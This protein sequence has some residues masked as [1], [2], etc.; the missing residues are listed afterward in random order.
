MLPISTTS[1]GEYVFP[2]HRAGAQGS[3]INQTNWFLLNQSAPF[4]GPGLR[5]LGNNASRVQG[6]SWLEIWLVESLVG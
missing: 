4:A 6:V 5:G 3:K 2:R 1:S